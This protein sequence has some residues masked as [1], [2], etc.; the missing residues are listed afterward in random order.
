M[1]LSAFG[2]SDIGCVR[3]RNE[4]AFLADESNGLFAVADG[5]GGLP[6]GAEASSLAIRTLAEKV[7]ADDIPGI[8]EMEEL[9]EAVNAAVSI[10]GQ[11]IDPIIGIGTTLTVVQ[12]IQRSFLV[13]HVGDSAAF[14]LR[15]GELQKLTT[16][17]T[18]EQQLIN[19]IGPVA[20]EDMPV[21]YPH[22][23]T[24]CIGQEALTLECQRH[25]A[26]SGD[27]IL[28]CSDGLS[29]VLSSA[30]IKRILSKGD[31]GERICEAFVETARK[32]GGP[33]NITAVVILLQDN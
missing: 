33:D 14:L 11:E 7:R 17:H 26:Q 32:S 10:H 21:E 29:K 18:M 8:A 15:D 6:G 28:L 16:D 2:I 27:R 3:E 24:S 1:Q 22:T 12:M 30:R 19:A 5:L 23:L 4:D 9:F 31:D 20:P 13:G 25:D